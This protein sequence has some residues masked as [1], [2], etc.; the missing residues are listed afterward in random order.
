[1][2]RRSFLCRGVAAAALLGIAAAPGLRAQVDPRAWKPAPAP[3]MTRWAKDVRPDR[4]RPE[5]PRPLLVRK[6]W[7]SLNGLW[8]FA[9]DDKNE[10]RTQGWTAGKTLPMQIL[11]PFTFEASLSGI[12]KG[13]E[14]HER[15]WYR[16]TFDVPEAWRRDG[17]RVLLNFGAV[18]WESTVWV[19][20]REIGT[21]RGGY[22]P[23]SY[24]VTDA[25]KPGGGAQEIVVAVY[26]PADPGKGAYQPKGKQLGSEGIFYTRTTGIW[27]T[28]WL[29]PVSP[30]HLAKVRLTPERNSGASTWRLRADVTLPADR[31]RSADP[32]RLEVFVRF[33]GQQ[34]GAFAFETPGRVL[35][36]TSATVPITVP[37]S[38]AQLWTPERPDLYDVKVTLRRGERVLD[39]ITSYTALREVG[40]RNGR[41]TLN[42]RPYFYRGVLDQGYWPDGI[43]TP[44]TDA[45][46]RYDV[47]ITKKMGFNMSRKHVKVEDPRWYYWCDKLGLA[48]WQDMP[49]A[50]APLHTNAEA[51]RNFTQEWR[52][53]IDATRD[54]PSVV[55][56]IPF[57]EN[58]G[59]PR[60]FQDETVT[61]TRQID[62]SR[63]IT[64]AS[65]WTQR[66][67]TDVID[68]H[69][70]SNNLRAQGVA[71]PTK[72]KVVGEYGGIALP[73]EGHTWT[74]GWGY[75]T[76][77]TP[78]A[79]LRRVRFQTSQLFDAAN[80][81]GFVY[82]QLSDVEQEMNGLLT[83]DR[84]LKAPAE[85]FARIFNGSDRAPAGEFA[86]YL[87]DW[88][89]L[90]PLPTGTTL[91][92]GQ[93]SPN[94]RA[95]FD[96]V[97]AQAFVPNEGSL[98][99]TDG[100]AGGTAGGSEVKWKRVQATGDQLDFQR[101][102]GGETN[103]AVA[104]AVAY[105][106][107]PTEVRNATLHFG[108]DD[109]ARVWLNGRQ[110]WT[111]NR[112]RGV[113]LDEDEVPGLTLKAGRNVLVVKVAQGVG[114]WGVAARFEKADG[115]SLQPGR[116]AAR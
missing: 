27:Q 82:T 10:G 62:P 99:P 5:Y 107:S 91:T 104:Y 52:D 90:G 88:L 93:D 89:V 51:Q 83:Y 114:G 87:R 33:K 3:L 7:K 43:L 60:A 29:E 98:A 41:L 61:L 48:V 32:I 40:I 70:Y 80:L 26:D 25:L 74:T 71:N 73:V 85:R 66:G 102:F 63:P 19:N 64:D 58:W 54:Y 13:K 28:V 68:A 78:E 95:I 59:D 67:L 15:V 65:G 30:V 47:E 8:E 97:L 39:E 86:G 49:S 100:A 110:V 44:P 12:G 103:N 106:D 16:R 56:W 84:L 96:K 6:D 108:S 105:F 17:K 77:R 4:A 112:V 36:E 72:P 92:S 101:A 53:V 38:I 94:A 45:A 79:L 34:I 109:A 42:G 11:V 116:T 76:V 81:S 23:F 21:R 57:N 50:H 1:M 111:V 35:H 75:Q 37:L 31:A 69:D 2:D 18:D 113:N 115:T 9:F 24:D 14:V 46:L 20:G 22:T 55:H